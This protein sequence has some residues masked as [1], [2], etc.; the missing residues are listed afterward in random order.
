[1]V[2]TGGCDNQMCISAIRS[3]PT[4]IYSRAQYTQNVGPTSL[5]PEYLHTVLRFEQKNPSKFVASVPSFRIP[6]YS[7][8]INY[9]NIPCYTM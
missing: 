8:S 2:N 5:K 9:R 3:P 7:L 1:M 4:S 6:A